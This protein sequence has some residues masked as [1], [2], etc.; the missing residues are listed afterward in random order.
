[1]KRQTD[2]YV[3]YLQGSNLG[4]RRAE[5]RGLH[6]S[7]P[8]PANWKRIPMILTMVPHERSQPGNRG[9]RVLE[10]VR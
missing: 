3:G 7:V 4:S 1:V 9:G 10:D 5:G 2:G 8:F 6:E